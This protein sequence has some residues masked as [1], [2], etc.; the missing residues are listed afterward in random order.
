MNT[1]QSSRIHGKHW[2][3]STRLLDQVRERSRYL[4]YSLRTEQAYLLW[5]KAFIRHHGLQHPRGF[6]GPEVE[7]F[8]NA[9]VN[10][11]HVS[12]DP[13]A[14]RPDAGRAGSRRPRALRLWPSLMEALQ[15]RIKDVDFD[16][17]V[18]VARS[19]RGG[20]DRVVM[21]PRSLVVRSTMYDIRDLCD[22][23]IRRGVHAPP[24]RFLSDPHPGAGG[25]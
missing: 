13:H 12:A 7:A 24:R 25:G 4:H 11:R 8:L 14:A 19:G 17:Y 6:G 20:K 5:I 23:A 9:L 3:Q 10:E 1:A 21:L 18:I 15:L 22:T 2:L 16:Q